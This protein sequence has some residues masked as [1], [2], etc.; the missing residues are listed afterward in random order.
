MKSFALN[1]RLSKPP[2]TNVDDLAQPLV[3]ALAGLLSLAV[4]VGIGRFTFIPLLPMMLHDGVAS[5]PQAS[6]LAT[7]NYFGYWVGAILYALQHWA[8]A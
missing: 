3:I 6:A 8:S 2:A 5:L 1:H 7:A 4:A